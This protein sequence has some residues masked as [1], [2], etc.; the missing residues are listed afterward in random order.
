MIVGV[1]QISGQPVITG[2]LIFMKDCFDLIRD[3]IGME[4]RSPKEIEKAIIQ[5]IPSLMNLKVNVEYEFKLLEYTNGIH[6]E[7][8]VTKKRP[9]AFTN[10]YLNQALQ[11]ASNE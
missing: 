8:Y 4:T 7:L 6:T 3:D 9:S 1:L 10:K 2:D 5:L 11:K